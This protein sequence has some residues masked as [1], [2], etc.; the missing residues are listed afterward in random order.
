MNLAIGFLLGLSIG[1]AAMIGHG[2]RGWQDRMRSMQA[3]CEQKVSPPETAFVMWNE[4]DG[5]RCGA[6]Y[7][8][9]RLW[10]PGPQLRGL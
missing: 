8:A 9:P 5:F 1:I 7:R 10:R 4:Q 2:E 6:V 3:A